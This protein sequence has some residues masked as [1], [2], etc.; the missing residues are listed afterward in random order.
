M[1]RREFLKSA[2]L[3]V[4]AAG[5]AFGFPSIVRA[6]A[7][8]K[9][10]AVAPSNRIH[11]AS[12]GLGQMGMP[13]LQSFLGKD[14]VQLVALCDVDKV[15]LGKGKEIVDAQYGNSDCA[16]YGD[17]RELFA[18]GDLDAVVI[19]LPDHWHAV[20][21]VAA[22]KAGMDVY[23][24]KPLSYSLNEGRAM[25]EAVKRYGRIWQ[26][27]SW[28]RSKAEFHRACEL[29]RNGRIGR[30]H[31]VELGL[32]KGF[33]DYEGTAHLTSPEPPPPTLDYEM[34]LGPAPWAPYCRAR[35]HKTWRWNL[36]YGGGKLMDWIGH[37]G[38]IAHWALGFDR[39]GPVEVNAKAEFGTGFWNAMLFFESECTYANGV[40]I[41][42]GS[43]YQ[44]GTTF[45]GDKGWLH[46][47]R[48]TLETSD[49][50]VLKEVIGPEETQLYVST[51]HTQNFLDCIKSR[52]ETITPVETAHRSASIGHLSLISMRLG[53]KLAWDP[54][55]EHF[56]N[57]PEADRMLGRTMRG[58]WH[59]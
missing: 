11:V 14:E 34:W 48:S 52:Q 6:S 18:R 24:E 28:Q 33:R 56:V 22:L 19:S 1:N 23:G 13:N 40:K 9:D 58:P 46:V 25:C 15:L 12:L 17:F 21:S 35:L 53:R 36:D 16:T 7:L 8:G 39:T 49:P 10:G 41:R 47:D 38:D 42:L 26:T 44:S 55:H 43:D 32:Q 2:G 29:V 27:G 54:E 37:H 20:A 30:V 59:V 50:K 31:T 3:Q 51:D 5:V 4:A 57:D 45:Y